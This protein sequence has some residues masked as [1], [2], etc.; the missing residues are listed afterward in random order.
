MPPTA[1]VRR[2]AQAVFEIAIENDQL[3]QWLGDLRLLGA[4]VETE[5]FGELLD[6]PQI[7]A[8]RKVAVVDE[9]FGDSVGQLARNLIALLATRNLTGITP[10]VADEYARLMDA[11]QGIQRAEV[12]TAVPM[13]DEQQAKVTAMLRDVVGQDVVLSARVDPDVLGGVVARVGD[14]IIDGST[15]TRLDNLRRNLAE[16]AG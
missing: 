4:A 16:R 15:R 1:S 13:N 8:D 6:S 12:V 14:R 3:E 7:P 5:G 9:A 10:S 2:Y 11:H